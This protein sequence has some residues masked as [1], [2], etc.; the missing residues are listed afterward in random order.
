[1]RTAIL[2]AE[3]F[4]LADTEIPSPG[5]GEVLVKTLS[6]GVCGGDLQQY[7]DRALLANDKTLLGHEGS[8]VV[9]ALG[10]GTTGFMVG[11]VVTSLDG[12]YADYFT[13]RVE[14][15]LK[16]PDGLDPMLALGEPIACCVHAVNRFSDVRGRATAVIGCGFMG[17]ICLQLLKIRGAAEIVAI[18]LH[19]G[20]RR[21]AMDLGADRAISPTDLPS[22][23]PET[24]LYDCVLE[25]AGAQSA[26]DLAT[27]LVTQHG[28]LNLVGYHES[29]E[30]VR[31]VNMK[32]W[33]YKAIDVLN[34][35]VRRMDEKLA[36]MRDGLELMQQG[37]L[38]TE[39]LVTP[40]PLENVQDAF[41]DFAAAKEGLFKAIL[42]PERS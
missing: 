23:D 25:A 28:S 29:G 35:H 2:T 32:L 15:L 11:D 5:P 34:G 27:N 13:C 4:T 1:M 40:Y 30:G 26:V 9:A 10:D 6:C 18:D 22:Y 16:V 33:N 38:V 31:S 12:G 7:R 19:E 14:E 42:L 21:T 20:R 8:G 41:A 24:G 37:L 3:G 17:L 39:P 36:A